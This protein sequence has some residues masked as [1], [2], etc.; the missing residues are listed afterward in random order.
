MPGFPAGIRAQVADGS[1]VAPGPRLAWAG[2][3][4]GIGCGLAGHLTY[5]GSQSWL[6]AVSW[7]AH[8]TTDAPSA[9][10]FPETPTT[11]PELRFSK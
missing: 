3:G 2:R 7:S 10:L 1:A 8:W 5:M 9:V 4:S 6:F 11:R